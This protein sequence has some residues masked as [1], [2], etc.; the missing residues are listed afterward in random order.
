LNIKGNKSLSSS[1]WTQFNASSKTACSDY[2]S[3]MDMDEIIDNYKKMQK[4]LQT[5][6]IK[7]QDLKTKDKKLMHEF[8]KLRSEL[9][10]MRKVTQIF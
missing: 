7:Y 2:V 9:E 3:K 10:D 1:Y 5:T 4:E 6:K 8:A